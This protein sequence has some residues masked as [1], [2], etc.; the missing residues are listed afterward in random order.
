MAL[1]I[2]TIEVIDRVDGQPSIILANG[3][4]AQW[5]NELRKY[6]DTGARALPEDDADIIRYFKLTNTSE[7]PPPVTQTGGWAS[8]DELD[9]ALIA[10]GWNL[11]PK[12]VAKD[13]RFQ[14][15]AVYQKEQVPTPDP[16]SGMIKFV[17]KFS[18]SVIG[19]YNNFAPSPVVTFD[20]INKTIIIT[21]P[22]GSEQSVKIPTPESVKALSELVAGLKKQVDKAI[23][24]YESSGVPTMD[25]AIVMD[26]LKREDGT[27]ITDDETKADVFSTHVGD[28]YTDL[29][30]NLAYR[31]SLKEG[32]VSTNPADYE[33]K[34]VKDG[35]LTAAISRINEMEG[36]TVKIWTTPP[37][38]GDSYK[39]GDL[40]LYQDSVTQE[41][42]YKT[43]I[44]S[45]TP[46][47]YVYAEADW[48]EPYATLKEVADL[49]AKYDS[50]SS[51]L[52]TAK[53]NISDLTSYTDNLKSWWTE[54]A[55]DNLIT[56]QEKAN[57]DDMH[58][59]ID[60][61]Q[62]QLQSNVDY[63]LTSQFFTDKDA[64]TI[65]ANAVLAPTT[66]SIDK[67]QTAITDAV[68][69]STIT[70]AERTAVTNAWNTY[71]STRDTLLT[72]IKEANT[73]IDAELK[74]LAD[75]K[76]DGLEIGGRN[77]YSKNT[78]I[79]SRYRTSVTNRNEG[80]TIN[81]FKITSVDPY[82]NNYVRLAKVINGNGWWTVSFDV[83]SDDATHV[84]IDIADRFD[85]LQG[86]YREISSEWRRVTCTV[87]VDNYS[88]AMYHFVDIGTSPYEANSIEVRNIKVEKGNKATDWTPAPEDIEAQID[89]INANPPRINPTTKN[90]EVYKFIDGIGKYVDTGDTSIGDDGKA[91]EIRDGY[92]WIFNGTEYVNSEIKALGEKGEDALSVK[93]QRQ[94]RFYTVYRTVDASGNILPEPQAVK[95]VEGG[96]NGNV[97]I[98]AVFRKG[99]RDVTS[100]AVADANLVWKLN[101]TQVASGTDTLQLSVGDHVDGVTDDVELVWDD[102]NA[103]NW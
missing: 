50:L 101:G 88:E 62:S 34:L 45:N 97:V 32:G 52:S 49:E 73:A 33:W 47:Q 76:V 46:P 35:A 68:A 48:V 102:T 36:S 78:P 69:D 41:W 83:R 13:N 55:K 16:E 22:D 14:W 37:A 66:G 92:W 98:K 19:L 93:L 27:A 84:R 103:A 67:L 7:T 24:S 1:Q 61:E 64:F 85:A 54:S 65:K 40:L 71:N 63:I 75:E 18:F 28:M 96:E 79:S 60:E 23:Y 3:N 74:R 53:E 31:F 44:K 25:G 10:E 51:D 11:D 42:R 95:K 2:E 9:A 80:E 87:D 99:S 15:M 89:A 38:D 39:Q 6:I 81:G 21:N 72:A 57:L 43:C 5:S 20:E 30:T 58:R 17:P 77:F 82:T 70:E 8:I 91:P 59:R 94:G 100:N 90:W 29:D 56:A 26:W 4:W 86:G 12:S